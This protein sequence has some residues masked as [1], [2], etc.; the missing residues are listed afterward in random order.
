MKTLLAFCFLLLIF[1]KSHAQ[2]GYAISGVIKDK[3]GETLPG[4]GVYL[5]NY[6]IA[7]VTDNDGN[8]VIPNLKPG[9]YDVLVQMMGFLPYTKNVVISD[10][11][12]SV[13]IVLQ[14]NTI[15]LNEVVIQA[16]PNREKYINMFKEFFI[17][18]TPNSAKCRLLNPNVLYVKFDR[19]ANV[20]D[21]RSNEFLIIENYALGYRLKY[22]LQ[23]F[24][25]NFN[26]RIVYYSGL[27]NFEE[28]KGSKAKKR[29][30]IAAREV[31]Y[32][33]SQQ[34]FFKSLYQG[35][36]KEDGFIINKLVK[37]KNPNRPPDALI[38]KNLE[39][40]K[41]EMHGI[42]KM[43]SAV[44]DSMG[45]WTTIKKMPA[46][47]STVDRNEVLPDTLV[48]QFY[49]DLKTINYTQDLYVIYTKETEAVD[50]SNTSGHWVMRPL[51]MP[52]YEISV[53]KKLE[54]GPVHFYANGGMAQSKSLLFEGFWAYEKIGDLVPMDYIPLKSK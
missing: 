16:D 32:Y 31:A 6:K 28:L 52:N 3:K 29:M 45:L 47:I 10:R 1:G 49:R 18:K 24:E 36:T 2:K 41:K 22:L 51:D 13:N 40:F 5:S 9:N 15:L 27:P 23:H 30:W 34:H 33:G 11:S 8:F 37:I 14:E 35:T 19:D 50:Y 20:L 25:Y 46:E 4:A 38:N 12:V 39:R 43:G 26:T 17:G 21:V 44:T 48:K 42:Y 7:T 54:E 53:V